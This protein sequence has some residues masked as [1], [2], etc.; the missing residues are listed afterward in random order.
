[1]MD[2]ADKPAKTARGDGSHASIGSL[3]FLI[4]KDLRTALDRDLAEFK[5]RAQPAAVLMHCCRQRGASPSSLAADVGTDTA[6][7]TGL[8]DQLERNGLVT[9]RAHPSDRRA[10]IVAPT[11]AGL[12]LLPRLAGVFRKLN[13]EL[14]KGFSQEETAGL[15]RLLH[16]LRNNLAE[17]REGGMAG[18]LAGKKELF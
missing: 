4:S 13:K 8:I 12:A 14:L 18:K 2:S 11:Q 7:I 16:R 5:L 17:T 1:M 15:D 6:G 9:R 10:L 3:C